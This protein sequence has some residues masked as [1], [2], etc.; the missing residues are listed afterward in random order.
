[1]RCDQC[2]R[3]VAFD[4]EV[5]PEVDVTIEY[6]EKKNVLVQGSVRIVNQCAECGSEMTE[7]TFDVDEVILLSHEKGCK[8]DEDEPEYD[9]PTAERFDDYVP[10]G[11]PARYQKHEYGASM[12]VEVSC[13]DCEVKG[14]LTWSDQIQS[15]GMDP[16]M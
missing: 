8:T 1:M 16:L 3:Y 4:S 6:D 14:S 12:D 11:R 2:G 5:E 13:A 15:S 7:A 9:E 10:P